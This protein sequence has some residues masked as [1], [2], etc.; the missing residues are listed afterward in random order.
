M[1]RARRAGSEVSVA[2]S[3]LPRRSTGRLPGRAVQRRAG[4]GHDGGL[5][6]ADRQAGPFDGRQVEQGVREPP[7]AEPCLRGPVG[8]R[9]AAGGIDRRGRTVEEAAGGVGPRP[10]GHGAQ[11]PHEGG[12][13][14]FEHRPR[15]GRGVGHH[16]DARVGQQPR[17]VAVLEEGAQ[18]GG[19][20]LDDHAGEEAAGRE[21]GGGYEAAAEPEEDRDPA[22]GSVSASRRASRT[23]STRE[24][25]AGPS[26]RTG[27]TGTGSRCDERQVRVRRGGPHGP[28]ECGVAERERA[29][30]GREQRVHGTGAPAP[31][32]ASSERTNVPASSSRRMAAA[33]APVSSPSRCRRFAS[34]RSRAAACHARSASS[35]DSASTSSQEPARARAAPR[36]RISA[37]RE[38]TPRAA[39][40]RAAAEGHRG[41]GFSRTPAGQGGA[42]ATSSPNRAPSSG[43]APG[44]STGEG[45]RRKTLPRT[46]EAR[47]ESHPA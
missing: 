45:W 38:R 11:V 9:E 25:S 28:G 19:A 41:C 46:A 12:G 34:I 7:P 5:D 10:Q 30:V 33:R 26:R 40:L 4:A 42:V 3:S 8:G 29:K 6:R 18:D 37:Q 47:C 20:A 43:S 14:G 2:A 35:G 23:G 36:P 24:C 32:R 13:P 39:S 16:R 1:P 21:E 17:Q 15:D 22:G 44:R 31:S 27:T